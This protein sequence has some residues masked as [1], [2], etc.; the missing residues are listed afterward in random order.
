MRYQVA[1]AATDLLRAVCKHKL[2]VCL[3]LLPAPEHANAARICKC[4]IQRRTRLEFKEFAFNC[5]QT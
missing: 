4:V 5:S 2:Q 1:G 3:P